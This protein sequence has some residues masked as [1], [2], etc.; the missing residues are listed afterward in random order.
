MSS[1]NIP[2]TKTTRTIG[3]PGRAP[4]SATKKI[5]FSAPKS[6]LPKQS[7]AHDLRERLN[8]KNSDD[9][10]NTAFA[11]TPTTQARDAIRS[12]SL[13]SKSINSLNTCATPSSL[14]RGSTQIPSTTSSSSSVQKTLPNTPRSIGKRLFGSS[15]SS[16]TGTP[17]CFSKVSL[18]T[19]T[20]R[21]QRP[22]SDTPR[23]SNKNDDS[24][25][26]KAINS[27]ISKI[28]VG[29]RVR[30]MNTKECT[31]PSAINVV[32][33]DGKEL[34]V[35]AGTNADSSAGVS[36]SFFYDHVFWSCNSTHDNFADQ[37]KVFNETTMP[38][39]DNAFEGY[40]ACLFAYGQTGS[41]KSYSMTGIDSGKRWYYDEMIDEHNKNKIYYILDDATSK[42]NSE[43]GIIP[44]FCY[45]LFRRINKLKGKMTAEIEIS[46]F[47]IYNEKV[48]DL[49][50]VTPSMIGNQI[51]TP[52]QI[53]RPTLK[54]RSHP[55]W[56]PYVVD[57]NIHPVD[58]HAALKNW[59]AVG[60]SQRATAATGMNDKSSRSHSIFN[61]ILNLSETIEDGSTSKM[62]TKRSKISLVDLAGSERVSHTCASGDRL[63]EGV[64]INKSLLT[65]GMVIKALADGKKNTYVPYR[66]SVLTWLLKVS[67]QQ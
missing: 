56:G 34:T 32:S 31:T 18:G 25:E 13:K 6:N 26:S 48:H 45:E 11:F 22:A 10:M 37:E 62:L 23:I 20:P 66:E 53:K 3:T 12:A 47:E 65:L 42:P 61:V 57:L 29:V 8:L 55:T 40:N 33:V 28:T 7:S 41:G 9:V 30:P 59:L 51:S 2:I 1:R 49:L 46:Y 39:I 67:K 5:P 19:P 15:T 44:R 35:L 4:I 27:E 50:S 64:S 38:L 60:N 21:A 43:S 52:N 36:H 54:V 63:K 58:S 17:E 16:I 24:S 14:V